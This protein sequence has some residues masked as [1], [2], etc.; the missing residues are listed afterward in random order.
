MN[1]TKLLPRPALAGL[2]LIALTACHG[3]NS[4]GTN[5]STPPIS[6]PGEELPDNGDPGTGDP[7]T[8]D[9]GTGNP[10]TGAKGRVFFIDD[11]ADEEDKA[12]AA[13]FSARNGDTIEFGE[14]TFD[15]TTT[16][17]MSHKSNITIKGQ[18]MDK[19][20]LLYTSPSPRDGLLSR[21]PSSA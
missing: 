12:L 5:G 7:G 3:G 21:M 20:C 8:G 2:L 16:L 17:V 4:S 11:S 13:F 9:P 1:L 14:G 18:G 15:L 6:T 10:G 19:T